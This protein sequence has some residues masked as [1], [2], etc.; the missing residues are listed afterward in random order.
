MKDLDMNNSISIVII[1]LLLLILYKIYKKTENFNSPYQTVVDDYNKSNNIIKMNNL[2]VTGNL[3]FFA[4]KGIIVA[5]HDTINN[6]PSGWGIC[7]GTKY[8][9]FD[10]SIIQSPDLREKFIVCASKPNTSSTGIADGWG[11]TGQPNIPPSSNNNRTPLTP[12]EVGKNGGT[13]THTLTSD[14]LP[15]HTHVVSEVLSWHVNVHGPIA[16]GNN[17]YSAPTTTGETGGNTS[18]TANP[19][20]N[21]PPYYSLVYIIKL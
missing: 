17:G 6:I 7:D 21:M 4:L 11:P 1:I 3:N 10:G 5:W 19:H 9:A 14:E 20:N 12:H 15:S 2:N 16:S 13:Q 18:G 8:K